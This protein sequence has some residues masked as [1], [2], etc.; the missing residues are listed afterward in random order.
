MRCEREHRSRLPREVERLLE[1]LC[2]DYPRRQRVLERQD[3]RADVLRHY[4]Y[5][6]A[7]TRDALL[8]ICGEEHFDLFLQDIAG[9]RSRSRSPQYWLH[10][11]TYAMKKRQGKFA[12]ARRLR[13]F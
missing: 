7:A 13:L 10:P 1:D 2:L 3:A 11:S 5:L 6:N 4:R 8:P 12:L 9:R